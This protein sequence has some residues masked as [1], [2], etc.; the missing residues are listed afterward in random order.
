MA[1]TGS[2]RSGL[3]VPL[4][5]APSSQSWEIG[6]IGDIGA[7][8]RWLE[9][10]G[11]RLLQLLRINEM[12]PNESS[13]YSALSAMAIDPLFI[14][15]G[16]VEDFLA[17]GGEGH[18]EPGLRTRLENVRGALGVDYPNVCDLKRM[19]LRRAFV[20]FRDSE[21]ARNT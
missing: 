4:F 15:V 6:D 11:L 19:V 13:P 2:R 1:P 16:R 7:M 5:S 8:T 18:L 17:L 9:T 21:W 14:A 12:P 3:L 10:A 20:Q